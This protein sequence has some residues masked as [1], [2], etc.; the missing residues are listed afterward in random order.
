MLKFL[1]PF[2]FLGEMSEPE[3]STGYRERQPVFAQKMMVATANPHAT[4]AA[5]QILEEG[6]SSIDAL[7]TAQ[8][9]LNVVEP[10]SSGIGGGAFLLYFDK[11]DER[12]VFF[13]GRETAPIL[14]DE[15]LFLT[16]GIF[17]PHDELINGGRSVGVPGV[18]RML[19]LAHQKKGRL[20]W[21]K[22]FARAIDLAE[23]GFPLSPRLHQ[24]I[25]TTPGLN[26]F[27]EAQKLFFESDGTTPKPTG[28]LLKNPSLAAT[29][30]L[31]ADEGSSPFYEGALAYKIVEAVQHSEVNPGL[32]SLSDL[33]NYRP[34]ICSPLF[35]N[36]RSYTIVTAPPPSS[37]GITL[38]QILGICETQNFAHLSLG[39]P[40]FIDLFCQASRLAYADR[41]M[42]IADPAFFPTP[43][44]A[45][46][47]K[48]YLNSRSKL[49]GTK[50]AF[51]NVE[52]GEWPKSWMAKPQN[53]CTEGESPEF[54]STTHISIIDSEGNA[55]SMTSSIENAFGSK[56]MAAGFFLN[57][58]LTDFAINPEKEGKK[59]A[60]RVQGG[61]RPLSSMTPTLV[62]DRD[63]G[64]FLTVGSAGGSLIIEYVAEV[65]FGVLDFKMNIQEAISFPHYASLLKPIELE[66]DTFI[67]ETRKE[68][69][70]LD[71][72]VEITSMNSGSVGIEVTQ[73]NLIGG[74]DPRRE[75]L[76]SG[77]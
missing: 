19:E 34:L 50:Y 5:L 36:Y 30:R 33:A 47:S 49:L 68:L 53:C 69:E 40:Q 46:I 6:G 27:E 23:K 48:S 20:P 9:V 3:S 1:F 18:L 63:G 2:I 73:K 60:N 37:G 56:V 70:A 7:I 62:F 41:N 55:V 32:L 54:P 43:V 42:Y 11:K 13:D 45:L 64:L 8:A 52:A 74:V 51:G 38:A 22:L 4:E 76:A 17:P 21:K 75:G 57:N 61:K 71:N 77:I 28:S 31:I 14:A 16:N 25:A 35:F 12:V 26:N 67:V 24:L 65:L 44:P 58:Q 39:S 10:Q 29:L 66:E 59:V 15:N 72:D